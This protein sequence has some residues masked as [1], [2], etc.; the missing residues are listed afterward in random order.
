MYRVLIVE[1]D[2]QVAS[3]HSLYL[4]QAGFDV[5]GIAGDMKTALELL[6]QYQVHLILLDIYLP[7]GS[8]LQLLRK[9]RTEEQQIEV[10]MVS[11]A[12]DGAQIREAFRLG[13]LD[14]I[15]K[16]FTYDRL[17][18]G[19]EKFQIRYQILN[20]E[21]LS[22]KEVDLLAER[23]HESHVPLC[24]PK[25]IDRQTLKLV[26][27]AVLNVKAPFGVHEVGEE[28]QLSRVSAK[29][30]L[31]FLCDQKLLQQTYVYGNKGRPANLYQLAAA[32]QLQEMVERLDHM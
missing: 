31:D 16:P 14:Y 27:A 30:Y 5:V 12:K 15:M 1:D 20:K 2:P 13:C 7:G 6:S 8:G 24:L 17:Q 18:D 22:Q 29:K 21:T 3:I 28:I 32:A 10:I 26:C 25:G 11:A 4:A 9:I 23:Q 19:L